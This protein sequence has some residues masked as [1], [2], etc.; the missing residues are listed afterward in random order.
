[1]KRRCI[2][3]EDAAIKGK[4]YCSECAERSQRV[5][6]GVQKRLIEKRQLNK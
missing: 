6:E 3:C 5:H 1:M 4:D 2:L